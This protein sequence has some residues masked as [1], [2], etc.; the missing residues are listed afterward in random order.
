[1]SNL[2]A[3]QI[4]TT[5]AKKVGGPVKLMGI[6]SIGGYAIFRLG[7]EG[8]RKGIEAI[9]KHKNKKSKEGREQ[10]EYMVSKP[11]RDEYG[12]VLSVGDKI[13]VI[14]EVEKDVLLIEKLGDN[15]NP[16]C[17]SKEVLSEIATQSIGE[18]SFTFQDEETDQ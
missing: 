15:N 11:Y 1:M 10:L 7:E 18:I 4:M 5:L 14:D 12:L 3:Y 16:F 6:V 17:M 13:R 9:H 2:G 8:L